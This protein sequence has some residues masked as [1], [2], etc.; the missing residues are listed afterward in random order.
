MSIFLD[1]A[2][3]GDLEEGA[4]LNTDHRVEGWAPNETTVGQSSSRQQSEEETVY[5]N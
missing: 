3:K 5:G 4:K 2:A 1:E